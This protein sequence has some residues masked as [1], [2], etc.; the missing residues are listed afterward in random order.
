LV[1]YSFI[2]EEV[3]SEE[4]RRKGGREEGREERREE[5]GGIFLIQ[6]APTLPSA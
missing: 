1:S 4:G 2:Q 3:V 6:P 5:G